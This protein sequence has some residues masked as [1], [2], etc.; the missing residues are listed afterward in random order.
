MQE[1]EFISKIDCCFPY[2]APMEWRRIVLRAP[3]VS[4]NA[5]FMVVHELCRPPRSIDLPE[6]KARLII[7]HLY[8]HFKHPL[9]SVLGKAIEAHI[10][11][12]KLSVEKA[13]HLM[14]KVAAYPGQYNAL[15]ICYFSAN[16]KQG[17]LDGLYDQIA[18]NWTKA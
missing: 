4:S 8:R 12:K 15:S 14:R 10:T 18:D 11:G 7:E 17:K 6:K 9:K 5:A 13:G 1:H 16:D 3:R 2:K